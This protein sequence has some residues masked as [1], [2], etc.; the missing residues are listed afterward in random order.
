MKSLDRESCFQQRN[1]K[2]SKIKGYSLVLEKEIFR[3][4]YF[5]FISK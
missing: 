1:W 3:I 4:L 2:Q 5:P